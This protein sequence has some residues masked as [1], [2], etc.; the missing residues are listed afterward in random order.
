MVVPGQGSGAAFAAEGISINGEFSIAW[1]EFWEKRAIFR[2]SGSQTEFTCIWW[3]RE[4]KFVVEV[5]TP[6]GL[7]HA[8]PGPVFVLRSKGQGSR[9]RPGNQRPV[10][11]VQQFLHP[12]AGWG[13][14]SVRGKG[15][16]LCWA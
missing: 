13:R 7:I 14:G 10:S 1:L 8:I 9:S 12:G 5:N 3:G 16:P 11:E 2:F 6:A 4:G 15:A